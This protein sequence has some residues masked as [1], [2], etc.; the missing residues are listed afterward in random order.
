MLVVWDAFQTYENDRWNHL[1]IFGSET[2]G[3]GSTP[4]TPQ[5]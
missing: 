2:P 3:A 1:E 4:K 5:K